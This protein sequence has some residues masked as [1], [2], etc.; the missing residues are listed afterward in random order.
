VVDVGDD[1]QAA[2]AVQVVHGVS[3]LTGKRGS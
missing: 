3:L 2:E 1:R